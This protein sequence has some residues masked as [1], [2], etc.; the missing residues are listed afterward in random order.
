[1]CVAAQLVGGSGQVPI[2]IEVVDG[3]TQSLVRGAGPFLVSF[4][5]RHQVVT[6]CIRVLNVVFGIRGYTSWKSTATAHSWTTVSCGY[7][8]QGDC[9]V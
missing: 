4:P 8:D 5:S 1:M 9:N 3:T 6:V 7:I 2:Y